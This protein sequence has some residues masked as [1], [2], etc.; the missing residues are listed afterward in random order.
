MNSFIQLHA[1]DDVVIARTQIVG[2]AAVGVITARGLI[3]AGHKL[4]LR[5]IQLGAPS[6][7]LQP[8]HWFCQQTHRGG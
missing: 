7:P 4:A 1:D 5:A 3:P 8:D 6:A 2:G